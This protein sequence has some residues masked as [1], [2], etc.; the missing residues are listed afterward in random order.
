VTDDTLECPKCKTRIPLTAVVTATI[1]ARLRKQ[2]AAEVEKRE[3]EID[4][5][6]A[7]IK[8]AEKR[9]VDRVEELA[10]KRVKEL[11][12]KLT[13]RVRREVAEERD[14]ELVELQ[15]RLKLK[16]GRLKDFEK[17]ERDLVAKSDDVA[18]RER[19]LDLQ[20]KELL[21]AERDSLIEKVRKEETEKWKG[22]LG[23]H[24]ELLNRIKVRDDRLKAFEKREQE[25]VAK[26]EA[27]EERERRLGLDAKRAL[28]V[29]RDSLIE[30]VRQE[31]NERWEPQLREK[32]AEL[33][34]VKQALDRA[35]KAGT[36]GELAG[37][38]AER[39]L[40]ERLGDVFEEDQITPTGKGKRGADVLQVVR[41]GGSILW[42]SKDRYENWSNEWLPKL[43]RDR[44][45]AKASIGVL[46]TTVGP[47][48]KPV[49]SPSYEDG[50]VLSP[51]WAV[52]GVASLLRPLLAENARQ[53]R[54]Y[55]K[56]ESLQA[57]VY[58]WV[59][60]Q[61]FRNGIVAMSENLRTLER[62][63]GRAKLN[64]AKW[65]KRMEVGV[66]RTVRALGEFYGSAQG[67]A[68]L[69]DLPAL[70]LGGSSNPPND[71]D[72]SASTD[73]SGSDDGATK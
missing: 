66:E 42:E 6:E 20:V 7:A 4:A 28:T 70:S 54:L 14:A 56:Q 43:K 60:S 37:E 23:E 51:S 58:A 63:V 44:D 1:E 57:T 41:G 49:S 2:I 30:K 13:E 40:V 53:R 5:R 39:T 15:G 71:G 24:D 52:V 59:T 29:E 50:V 8:A 48:S 16:E 64:H 3:R 19:R 26:D 62:E 32:A 11:T 12:G 18:E 55:D 36:S 21:T 22:K 25:L 38:V 9:L 67:Q 34:R 65:F 17:R 10:G 69:P 45:E 61:E 72:D 33:E 27:L 46:V 68:R 35:Q 47:G 73:Q 31:E